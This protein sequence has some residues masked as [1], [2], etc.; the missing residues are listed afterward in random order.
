MTYLGT[1]M[2]FILILALVSTGWY[3]LFKRYERRMS[4]RFNDLVERSEEIMK[5]LHYLTQQLA[6]PQK[7]DMIQGLALL[8][9]QDSFL[10][11]S[12]AVGNKYRES[13]KIDDQT[14][15]RLEQLIDKIKLENYSRY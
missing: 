7:L 6:E 15:A 4:W 5:N 12:R 2:L 3:F 9:K 10:E 8:I 11:Y 1:T 14:H 13:G